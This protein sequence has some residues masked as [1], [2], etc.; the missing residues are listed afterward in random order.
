VHTA[1]CSLRDNRQTPTRPATLPDRTVFQVTTPSPSRAVS[2]ERMPLNRDLLTSACGWL[3]SSP[4][5]SLPPAVPRG[6]PTGNEGRH[7]SGQREGARKQ[8]ERRRTKSRA[9]ETAFDAIASS[10][11]KPVPWSQPV[12]L[13][14]AELLIVRRTRNMSRASRQCDRSTLR[15]V[16]STS[17]LAGAPVFGGQLLK[18]FE[19]PLIRC[20]S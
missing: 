11:S 17:A 3:F 12:L 9:I 5:Q 6:R 7:P 20:A 16:G 18:P 15:S 13:L 1:R 19:V 4:S 8:R 2:Q 10:Q 14:S